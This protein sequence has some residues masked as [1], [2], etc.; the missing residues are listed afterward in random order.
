M[1]KQEKKYYVGIDLGTSSCGWAVTDENYNLLR[2]KGKDAFGARLF[3]QADSAKGR[4]GKRTSRR[5]MARR[6]YRIQLLNEILG[7]ALE[8]KDPEFLIRLSYSRL[9]HED[10]KTASKKNLNSFPIFPSRKDEV[11]FYKCYPTI[12]HLRSALS[13]NDSKA[14]SDLR[15]VY[16]AIH[17]IIKYRGNFLWDGKRS[18]VLDDSQLNAILDDLNDTILNLPKDDERSSDALL[19]EENYG[20]LFRILENHEGK[21]HQQKRI[22]ALVDCQ[23]LNQKEYWSLFAKCVTGGKFSPIIQDDDDKS[24]FD[25]NH[26]DDDTMAECQDKMGDVFP[27]VESAKKIYDFFIL[28]KLLGPSKSVSGAMVAAYN[29]HHSDLMAAKHALHAIDRKLGTYNASD[30]KY[31][32]FFKDKKRNSNYAAYVGVDSFFGR[33][34]NKTNENLIKEFKALITGNEDAIS[35]EELKLLQRHLSD[36]EKSFMPLIAHLST[37]V[38]PH[39]LHE[40]E[41]QAILD[42]AS[43]YYPDIFTLENKSKIMAIF[44]Y[45]IP[46][47]FGPLFGPRSNIVRKDLNS[48][49]RISP[50]NIDD[51]VD[52]AKTREKFRNSLTNFCS[53]LHSETVM[54]K[55]SLDYEEYIILDRLNRIEVND[56]ELSGK[57]KENVLEY[58]LSRGKT[59]KGNLI[60]FFEQQGW[61]K[62]DIRISKM[63]ENLPFSATTHSYL[64]KQKFDLMRDHDKLED[65]IVIATI[66][67]ENKKDL[68]E[69]LQNRYPEYSE[70]QINILCGRKTCKWGRLS[71]RLLTELHPVDK[72]GVVQDCRN[73][74]EIRRTTNQDLEQIL[75]NP[76]YNFHSIID[77]ENEQESK[78]NQIGEILDNVPAPFRRSCYQCLRILGEIKRVTGND[79]EKIFFEVTREDLKSIDKKRTKSRSDLIKG[80]YN[81]LK[82]LKQAL[83]QVKFENLNMQLKGRDIVNDMSLRGKHLYLYF[84]QLGLDAYTGEPIDIDDV[85]KG[86]IYDTDHIIPQSLKKDDSL[87]NLVLVNRE[88]NTKVKSD[89]YPIPLKI[90]TEKVVRLWHY[91]HDNKL[92]SD[93]KYDNLRRNSILS[94][95][96]IKSFVSQQINAVNYSNRA[97][98]ELVHALYPNTQVIFSKAQYPSERRKTYHR[99]KLRDL[100]NAHH[101]RDAYLN[102]VCGDILSVE[103]T[104]KNISAFYDLKK[105]EIAKKEQ[106][107]SII[108]DK[109]NDEKSFNMVNCLNRHRRANKG[110]LMKKCQNVFHKHSALITFGLTY[111]DPAF[112]NAKASSIASKNGKVESLVPIHTSLKNPLFAALSDVTKYGGYDNSGT[113]YRYLISYCVSDGKKTTHFL[114]FLN[115]KNYIL[116]ICKSEDALRKKLY[117]LNKKDLGKVD[118]GKVHFLAKVINGQKIKYLGSIFLLSSSNALQVDCTNAQQI[119]ID[120]RFTDERMPLLY[121]E[122]L[123]FAF[124]NLKRFEKAQDSSLLVT[125]DK[126]KSVGITL[127]KERNIAILKK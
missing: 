64:R 34:K 80:L 93:K 48:T 11:K 84:R 67:A 9:N 37:S 26:F 21:V 13:K 62:Q 92:M 116:K 10:K 56:K 66:Y 95:N 82:D 51:I 14:F 18:G 105:E 24:S 12:W 43:L 94:E 17:H 32:Q 118:F 54:P 8:K 113:A 83:P 117:D 88:Y 29:Q 45:R 98:K 122:Y 59:T 69:V 15:Q 89:I 60:Y 90:K 97:L 103:Y 49:T 127:S 52:K 120:D 78:Q 68:K 41:L 44:K 87:D 99:P 102:I 71:K 126:E 6:K 20:E 23:D 30:S 72:D 25:F 39:Q 104:E 53:F 73:V 86:T 112:Y 121:T 2:L 28:K 31:F 22:K 70:K 115:V 111:A 40:N 79:P 27:V 50:F 85:L 35:P 110:E 106:N 57:E 58:I 65:I 124:N 16:L 19:S 123:K 38:I 100:N 107:P 76:E 42:N 75:N 109:K 46:F 119:Y 114:R 108:R 3:K 77:R 36:D 61:K 1:K 63:D 96:E 4:R 33:E 7:P 5:R 125:T 81:Q 101:A 55:A 74:L 47:Y 91:L